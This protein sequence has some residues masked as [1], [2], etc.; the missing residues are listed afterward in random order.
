MKRVLII[1]AI[2][3][4]SFSLFGQKKDIVKTGYNL[5][6]LPIVAFDADKGLQYGA[7][8]NLYDFGN[9]SNY[10]N[11]DSKITAEASFY[12]KGSNH[13]VLSYDNKTL[14]PNIRWSSA[15]F[16]SNDKA[17]DFLGFNGYQSWYDYER[18]AEGKANKIT[19]DPFKFNYSPYY[20]MARTNI[21]AKT[22]FIGHITKNF[23]WEAGYHFSYFKI[24]AI[25]RESINKGKKDYD[26]YPDIF[27]TLYED[28]LKAGLLSKDEAQ[29]GISSAIRLGLQYDSR[30]KE[31]AP[32]KGIWAE[33]HLIAAPKWLGSTNPYFRYSATFR[34]YLPLIKND[35]LTFAYRLNYMGTFGD[36]APFYVLSYMTTIGESWDKDGMGGYRNVRGMIRNRVVGLDM[37][38]YNAEFR[39]RF[40]KF[41]LF[42]QNIA[43]G[44][45]VFSDGTTVTKGRSLNVTE[46]LPGISAPAKGQDKDSFHI[47]AGAGFRFIMNENFI[48]AFEYGSPISNFL[49]KTNP[50]HGQD[51]PGAFYINTGYLF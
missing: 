20:K 22:D 33:A 4:C 40:T 10:P 49:P 7:Q 37:L 21:L 5:G 3:C 41:N 19:Q 50:L 45:S 23:Y 39:W 1:A 9:G 43:L 46:V 18:I 34:H 24:G 11:Y 38:T 35:I 30:D 26:I 44:L 15:V 12:S 17:M 25:N 28:Y 16:I 42:N 31:G 13:F 29:G 36:N 51:G 32:T 8:L 2:F 48:I 47:T 6:P 14:I 27:S